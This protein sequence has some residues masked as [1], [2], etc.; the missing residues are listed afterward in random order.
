MFI[1]NQTDYIRFLDWFTLKDIQLP[2]F[3]LEFILAKALKLGLNI[4][5][6]TYLLDFITTIIEAVCIFIGLLT[7][8]AFYT[9]AE[10][11]IMSAIQRRRGPNVAGV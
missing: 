8:V 5:E 9:L 1:L 7:A 3:N 11:K 6:N 10:R 2:K 4:L